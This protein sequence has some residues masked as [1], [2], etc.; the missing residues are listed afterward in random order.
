VYDVARANLL[1]LEDQ[2]ADSQVFNVGGDRKVSVLDYAHLV[3]KQAGVDI[4]PQLP[5]VYRFGDTRHVFSD[6]S[7]LKALGWAPMV[8]LEQ[9]VDEYI[10][11]AQAEPD[12]ADYYAEAEAQMAALGT[13]RRAFRKEVAPSW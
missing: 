1:V 12:F 7:R 5:G 4:E 9:I 2:R 11:W 13:L 10:A 6:V 3:A 8:S